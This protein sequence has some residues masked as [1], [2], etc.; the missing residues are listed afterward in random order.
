MSLPLLS[1]SLV[2]VTEDNRLTVL[3]V[4]GK[5][6]C[7]LISSLSDDTHWCAVTLGEQKRELKE[8]THNKEWVDKVS[9]LVYHLSYD[10]VYSWNNKTRITKSNNG[11]LGKEGLWNLTDPFTILFYPPN[12]VS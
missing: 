7:I 12:N 6:T 3:N 10:K 8:I 2:L 9:V 1:A 5:R 4:L 11:P